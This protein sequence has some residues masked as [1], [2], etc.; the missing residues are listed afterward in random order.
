VVK[1]Q[2]EGTAEGRAVVRLLTETNVPRRIPAEFHKYG[3]VD[4]DGYQFAPV[5]AEKP[6]WR[7]R[8]YGIRK[9]IVAHP[10]YNIPEVRHAVDTVTELLESGPDEIRVV[11]PT[12]GVLIINNHIAFHGRTAF[13]DPERHL[14]RLRFHEPSR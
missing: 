9:G 14:L 5:I 8:K 7:W 3:Y 2:L 1:K 13:T 6:M 4:S 10:D 12:D 11:I